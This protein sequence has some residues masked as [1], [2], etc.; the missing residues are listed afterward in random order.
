VFCFSVIPDEANVAS[1]IGKSLQQKRKRMLKP[2]KNRQGYSLLETMVVVAIV[3]ILAAVAVPNFILWN[4]KYQLKSEVANLAGFLG[5][6]RMTAINQNV[7]VVVTV[8]QAPPA[9]VVV[10]F[11]NPR[12]LPPADV[13]LP[14]IT[15]NSRVSLTDAVGGA[16]ASPQDL[17]FDPMGTWG[18]TANLNNIC[19]PGACPSTSQVLNFRSPG[20]DNFRIVVLGTGKII[21]C[22]VPTCTQ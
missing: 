13:V 22:Y 4:Q 16:G 10:T 3:G 18:N 6:A 15:M 21:W 9:A 5:F 1:E 7:P 14:P 2:A 11:T 8:T 20:V 12:L 17:R 19:I